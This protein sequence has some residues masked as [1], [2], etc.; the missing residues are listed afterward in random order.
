[1]STRHCQTTVKQCFNNQTIT[2]FGTKHLHRLAGSNPSRMGAYLFFVGPAAPL[3]PEIT[4][5][6]P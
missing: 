6:A 2:R 1:M 3:L 5:Q 4:T